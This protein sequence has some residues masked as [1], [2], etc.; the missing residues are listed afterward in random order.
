LL[1]V[2]LLLRVL[3]LPLL[4]LLLPLRQSLRLLRPRVCFGVLLNVVGQLLLSRAA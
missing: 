1:Q 4:L 2:L 3:L